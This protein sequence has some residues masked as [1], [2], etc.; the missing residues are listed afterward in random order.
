MS[1]CTVTLVHCF[2][3]LTNMGVYACM[4]HWN[5]SQKFRPVASLNSFNW[6]FQ[7]LYSCLANYIQLT[8]TWIR[9]IISLLEFTFGLFLWGYANTI[10]I[11]G[12]EG[13]SECNPENMLKLLFYLKP[14]PKSTI[15]TGH[16]CMIS[17][18]MNTQILKFPTRRCKVTKVKKIRKRQLDFYYRPVM[19]IKQLYSGYY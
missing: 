11:A 3:D 14:A 10:Q 2:V 17:V 6:R 13:R 18:A 15:E 16:G 1:L 12:R 7:H 5:Y 19:R 8:F 9:D 4:M